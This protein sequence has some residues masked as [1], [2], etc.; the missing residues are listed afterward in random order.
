MSDKWERIG[1]AVYIP[2]GGFDVRHCPDPQETAAKIVKA[3]NA[4]D[5]LV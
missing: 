2:G 1:T 5:R 4:H 3:V